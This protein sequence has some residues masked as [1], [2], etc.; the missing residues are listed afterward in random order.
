VVLEEREGREGGR[1]VGEEGRE[2]ICTGQ[3][4][5][6]ERM[7]STEGGRKG[8]RE[9]GRE[10]MREGGRARTSHMPLSGCWTSLS[11]MPPTRSFSCDEEMGGRE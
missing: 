10:E 9:G 5:K 7:P 2:T 11:A 1:E 3:R 4:D 6:K 8:G